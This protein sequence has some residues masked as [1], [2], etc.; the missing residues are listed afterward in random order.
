M[1]KIPWMGFMA[2]C[3]TMSK[4]EPYIHTLQLRT[5]KDEPTNSTCTL[6]SVSDVA[7]RPFGSSFG[8]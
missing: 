4:L 6:D 3:E 5:E 8:S 1:A 7:T 2:E